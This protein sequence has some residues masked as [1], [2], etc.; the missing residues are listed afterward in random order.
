MTP[1][2]L[3]G[4]FCCCRPAAR[5]LALILAKAGLPLALSRG[6]AENFTGTGATEGEQK[7]LLPA[8]DTPPGGNET[9][10]PSAKEGKAS[11]R[12]TLKNDTDITPAAS[13]DALAVSR[14]R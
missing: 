3:A 6:A 4:V 14:C 9:K 13:P 11:Y 8:S 2:P 1:E 12:N 5:P 10:K 7:R